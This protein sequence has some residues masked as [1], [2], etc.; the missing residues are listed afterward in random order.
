MDYTYKLGNAEIVIEDEKEHKY[1]KLKICQ[2]YLYSLYKE[3][4]F[5]T[6][7]RELKKTIFMYQ[8]VLESY[9]KIIAEIDCEKL[10]DDCP[11]EEVKKN[12]AEAKTALKN[13]K[14]LIEKE[15]ESEKQIFAYLTALSDR[16]PLISKFIVFVLF[17]IFLNVA[18]DIISDAYISS[19]KEQNAI[20]VNYEEEI[21]NEIREIKTILD[22]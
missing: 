1:E 2:M 9:K 19:R 13:V 12:T 10:V 5:D 15:N 22:E 17:A 14:D 7:L 20:S 3:K 18:S 16:H 8:S 6:V 11:D 4:N 21:L